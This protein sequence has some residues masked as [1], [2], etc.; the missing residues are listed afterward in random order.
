[1]KR[2]PDQSQSNNNNNFQIQL[3]NSNSKKILGTW[4]VTV[5]VGADEVTGVSDDNTNNIFP[6]LSF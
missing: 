1:M 2:E 5:A 6:T 4:S 3:P